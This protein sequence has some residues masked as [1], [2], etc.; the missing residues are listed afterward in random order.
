MKKYAYHRLVLSSGKVVR[1]PVVVTLDARSHIIE[2]HPLQCEEPM[3]EWV[4]GEFK[5][6]LCFS[7]Q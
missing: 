3:V 1:G 6:E 5:A 7:G 4:G 2:W